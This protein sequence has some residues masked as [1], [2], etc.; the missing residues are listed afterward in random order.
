MATAAATVA[1]KMPKSN[2]VHG[3]SFRGCYCSWKKPDTW[4][5]AEDL[6]T[7]LPW[8]EYLRQKIV[9]QH[10]D[11]DHVWNG[12]PYRIRGTDDIQKCSDK[13][14]ALR[15][16]LQQHV[17]GFKD[18]SDRPN[19]SVARH[20][21]PQALLECHR[22]WNM[23]ATTRFLSREQA[24][25]VAQKDQFGSGRFKENCNKVSKLLAKAGR[26]PSNPEDENKF[27]QAPVVTKIEVEDFRKAVA[28]AKDP[29][30]P[31]KRSFLELCNGDDF[32]TVK[33]KEKLFDEL[34]DKTKNSRGGA[35][36]KRF[37]SDTTGRGAKSEN[38]IAFRSEI[39]ALAKKG[40]GSKKGTV[41][42]SEGASK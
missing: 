28:S 6:D 21:F 39:K 13:V 41:L 25:L 37:K 14:V 9:A 29:K 10:A 36:V 15:M 27:I 23:K 7:T 40:R 1:I 20:H 24:E 32:L 19:F 8:C 38:S 16:S 18:Q 12:D 3:S 17:P 5:V 34:V 26:S 2:P 42:K 30:G 33:Q 11:T 35:V 22:V 4:P 31:L